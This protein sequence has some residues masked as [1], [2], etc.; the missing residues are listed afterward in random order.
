[1]ANKTISTSAMKRST[2]V[3][4]VVFAVF[5]VLLIRILFIQTV[6]FEKYQSKV[7]NQM[8]TES[9]VAASRGKIYDRNG[10]V[11]ATNTT[12]YR[13]F[14]SPSGIKNAQNEVEE[15]NNIKYAEL[16]S[17]GL[18]ELLDVPYDHIYKQATEYT[19]YLDRTIKR[20]V[21]EETADEVRAF[22]DEYKLNSM[23]Y[24]EAQSTRY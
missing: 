16:I 15:E 18:S 8:T 10:N 6:N 11:L 23:V 3:A 7:I 5:A 2:F 1:M 22:I 24:L 13:V 4:I 20:Q 21:Y 12:T 14:I 17:S 9:P 19:K